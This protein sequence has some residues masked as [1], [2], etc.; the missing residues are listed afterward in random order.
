MAQPL[1]P[2]EKEKLVNMFESL[3]IKPKMDDKAAFQQ[4]MED[5]LRAEGQL[6]QQPTDGNPTPPSTS[7]VTSRTSIVQ[8]P[9]IVPF[10][11]GNDAK[12]VSFETWLYEV[13][14]LLKDGTY[15]KKEV[16]TAAKKSLRGSAAS[17]ARRMKP[18]ASLDDLTYK[19]SCVFGIV[20][21]SDNLM[22]QF[23]STEQAADETVAKWA[24]RIEELL[25]R[26]CQQKPMDSKSKAEMLRFRFWSGLHHHLKEATRTKAERIKDF[27]RLL[28]EVRKIESEAP[29]Q[30]TRK[31]GSASSTKMMKCLATETDESDD[32]HSFKG[33][34]AK[35]N[36]RL[37]G[38]EKSMTTIADSKRVDANSNQQ[39]PQQQARPAW[40]QNR[41]R[42]NGQSRGFGRGRGRY[43]NHQSQNYRGNHNTQYQQQSNQ[44]QR[45]NNQSYRG[46]NSWN[47]PDHTPGWNNHLTNTFQQPSQGVQNNASSNDNTQSCPQ[48]ASSKRDIY[49]FRCGQL[50]H[51]AP[52][53]RVDLDHLN[54]E[55][56]V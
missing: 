43:Q 51:V 35:L 23:Y 1:T 16:E 14:T 17:V 6:P 54:Q 34:I 25:D 18:D 8:Q 47:K 12:D 15:S 2:D 30:H 55:E 56:S 3:E 4:W 39:P 9:R 10:S 22:T 38:L 41:G 11:G 52:G 13:E 24:C 33:M 20:E 45:H 36:C 50:G 44:Y 42:G 46:R 49:C 53:C 37:D 48:T 26:A 7:T 28:V 5:Y 40:D 21:Q 32:D 19:L 27:D 29:Y 31:E